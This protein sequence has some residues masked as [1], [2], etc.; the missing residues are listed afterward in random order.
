MAT[1]HPNDCNMY[2]YTALAFGWIIAIIT[3]LLNNILL[4]L[5][6]KVILIEHISDHQRFGIMEIFSFAF[7]FSEMNSHR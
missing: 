2:L 4:L 1:T 5:L 7:E 6:Y 3:H